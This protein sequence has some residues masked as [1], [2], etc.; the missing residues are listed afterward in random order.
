MKK[1]LPTQISSDCDNP[2]TKIPLLTAL[3]AAELF[4]DHPIELASQSLI[5]TEPTMSDLLE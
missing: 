4:V 3:Q 5:P 2:A 1:S